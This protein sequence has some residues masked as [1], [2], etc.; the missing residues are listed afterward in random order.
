[1]GNGPAACGRFIAAFGAQGGT[2]Y[3]EGLSF[4]QAQ[5]KHAEALAAEN[6][7]LR[8]RLKAAGGGEASPLEFQPSREPGGKKQFADVIKIRGGK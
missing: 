4:D 2:W 8:K 7:D 1:M 3:A 5:A 6:A